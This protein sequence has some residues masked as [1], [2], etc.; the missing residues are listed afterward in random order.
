M[1]YRNEGKI[2][3]MQNRKFPS[4]VIDYVKSNI[5]I[6]P[7]EFISSGPRGPG[8]PPPY[9]FSE[10]DLNLL[11]SFEFVPDN[12]PPPTNILNELRYAQPENKIWCS[13]YN[14]NYIVDF[15]F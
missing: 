1:S 9:N 10:V 11:R 6:G 15:G 2:T 7:I 4:S 5:L 8:D 14:C 13:R 3:E 12:S